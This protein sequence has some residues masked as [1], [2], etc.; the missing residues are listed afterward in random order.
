VKKIINFIKQ[1]D[2]VRSFQIFQILRFLTILITGI[3]LAKSKMNIRD[4]GSYESLIFFSG[5]VSFFWVSGLLNGLLSSYNKSIEAG[6]QSH[7]FNT[8]CSLYLLNSLLL[9]FLL[10][11]NQTAQRLL[12]D[13]AVDYYP[14]MLLY[15]FLNNPTFLIEHLLLLTNRTIGLLKY[16]LI[17]LIAYVSAVVA[18]VYLGY[19]LEYSFYCLIVLAVVKNI[20]LH[21][22]LTGCSQLQLNF[23]MIFDQILFSLPLIF[24]LLISGSAEYVDGLLVS[25]HF[26][27]DAFAIFRYGAKELPL[28]VLLSGAIS[29]ALVPKLAAAR[30]DKAGLN[31]LKKESGRLMHLLYPITIVLLLTSNYFYPIVFRAEFSSSAVIFNTYLLLLISRVVFPQ[32]LVIAAG[33]NNVIFKIA[34]VEITVNILVSYFLMLKLGII[35]IA[36]GTLAAFIAEKCC[37]AIYVHVKMKIP[38]SEYLQWKTWLFYSCLLVTVFFFHYFSTHH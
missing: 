2:T 23:K 8:A 25:T 11:F 31:Q 13:E 10:I 9:L 21:R 18:P 5:A 37:L 19:G 6:N 16:G 33:K 3:L 28:A 34:L 26:G 7:L 15:I 35:G 4:I 27:S 17:N 14:L 36:I 1:I 29:N 32:T 22:L 30:F 20:V 24:S 12:P 38:I